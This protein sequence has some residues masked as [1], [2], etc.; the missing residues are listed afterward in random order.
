MLQI[1]QVQTPQTQVQVIGNPATAG[2]DGILLQ[3]GKIFLAR[4]SNEMW[5]NGPGELLAPARKGS[6]ELPLDEIEK[7]H[8]SWQNGLLFDG[9]LATV[10]D[11]VHVNGLRKLSAHDRTEFAIRAPELQLTLNRPIQLFD[12]QA[13]DAAGAKPPDIAVESLQFVGPTVVTNQTR[14]AFDVQLSIDEL[15]TENLMLR[16]EEGTITGGP[17][18]VRTIRYGSQEAQGGGLPLQGA[19]NQAA[20]SSG[21]F[22]LEVHFQQKLQGNQLRRELSFFGNVRTLVGPVASWNDRL[23]P[24]RPGGLGP[25]GVEMTSQSLHVYE[26]EVP[27]QGPQ[28]ELVA[29]GN[30]QV[31]GEKFSAFADRVSYN[32]EKDLLI[33]KG[34]GPGRYA[35]VYSRFNG[36]PDEAQAR[37]L[38]IWPRSKRIVGDGINRIELRSLGN[39]PGTTR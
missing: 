20:D 23:D 31:M 24:Q 25:E 12:P 38:H 32:Q 8:V 39:T 27:D 30:T 19:T 16:P 35:K 18:L 33:L 11:R 28:V 4:A 37:E 1:S 29:Q 15:H 34:E 26:F 13:D 5:I 17:G 9:R 3:G 7:V 22:H 6:A 10:R 36:A 14:D 21:L 2:A